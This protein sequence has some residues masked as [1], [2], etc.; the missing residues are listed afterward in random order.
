MEQNVCSLAG[1]D[2]SSTLLVMFI[3][4]NIMQELGVSVR[5]THT[6]LEQITIASEIRRVWARSGTAARY[7]FRCCVGTA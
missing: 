3:D 5:K 2:R 1:C 6:S 7:M 4:A